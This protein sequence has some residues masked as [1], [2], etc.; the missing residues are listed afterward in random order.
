MFYTNIYQKY[1][2]LYI[3]GYDN[4]GKRFLKTENYKPYL[5]IDYNGTNNTKYKNIYGKPVDKI[6]FDSISEARKFVDKYFE[7]ENFNIYG[8]E[9]Y[10]YVYLYDNFYEFEYDFDFLN[11]IVLDIEVDS[12]NA[13]PDIEKAENEIIAIT[14]SNKKEKAVFGLKEYKTKT[15]NI[16]Y[17]YCKNEE[18]L[19]RLF[20]KVWNTNT[21]LP[22]ILT[23]WNVEFFDIPYLINR[24]KNVL[25]EN[26]VKTLSPWNIITKR[27]IGS[28]NKTQII[29]DIAGISILDYLTIYRNKKFNP[30]EQENYRLDTITE[31]ENLEIKKIN[32]KEM[33]YKNLFDLYD[34]NFQLFID[35]N[36]TDTTVIELLEEK[37]KFLEQIVA[38]AYDAK[39]NFSDVLTTVGIWDIIIHNYLMDRN[40]VVPYKK[41]KTQQQET[42]LIGGYV[43]DVQK[44]YYDWV[45]SFDLTSLYPHLIMQ[46]NISPETKISNR[47]LS[48][49]IQDIIEKNINLPAKYSCAA[50]GILF[51]KEKEG[52][53]PALMNKLFTE[54]SEYKRKM[55]EAK[56]LKADIEHEMKKRGLNV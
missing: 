55:L 53:L 50:N 12:R 20:L 25:G 5:F 28:N 26:L 51:T 18:D 52:F 24:I 41:G 31:V 29:Y 14:L 37:H 34:R 6:D 10:K 40:I 39:V 36:I 42:Q 45:V 2:T 49:D 54:R 43:K 3:K 46:Y 35:Y 7:V 38:I 33:G 21:F 16:K 8:S 23:G 1:N 11:V 22:D 32:Y 17:Y 9:N 19:L 27:N 15:E 48:I 30:E 44:S 4:K 47:K 13:F 56:K